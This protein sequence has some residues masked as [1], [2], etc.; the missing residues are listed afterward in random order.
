MKKIIFAIVVIAVAALAALNVTLVL[1]EDKPVLELS[2]KN[3]TALTGSES[4]PICS[5]CGGEAAYCTC[6]VG[7]TCP[8]GGCWGTWCH[9]N[10]YNPVCWCE[11]T[12][13]PITVCA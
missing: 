3:I 2:L 10:S 1:N 13:D 9:K 5:I 12:G 4:E 7:I 6:D 11:A 8:H